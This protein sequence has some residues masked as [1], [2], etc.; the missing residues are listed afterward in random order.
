MSKPLKRNRA[1]VAGATALVVLA[2]GGAYAAIQNDVLFGPDKTA[3]PK[4]A[5]K[6]VTPQGYAVAPAG[7][8]TTIGHLPLN[9]AL[10]P[11][12]RTLL[13]TNNGQATQSLQLIDTHTGQVTQTLP[14]ATPESLYIGL[15]WS[16]DGTRAY[17]S[18]AANSKIRVL[19]FAEGKLTEGKPIALPTSAPD[20]TAVKLFPAGLAI[21]ADG[22][23]L[24]VAGQLGNTLSSIDV[25]SGQIET[26]AVGH[27]PVWV[28]LSKNGRTAYVS[29]QGADTVS[30]VDVSKAVPVTTGSIKVGLHPNKS[31]LSANGSRLYVANGDADTVSEIRVP[32]GK[33]GRTF[34]VA[35]KGNTLI[36]ANPT[37]LALGKH[38]STLYVTN[39]GT[40]DVAAV[41]LRSGT[42]AG[43]IP[44][45]WY[46][47]SITMAGDKLLV[48]NAKGYGA[49]PNNGPG[50]PNPESTATRSPDQY[51]G[52]MI[53]G[54]I[55]TI[56]APSGD[57]L[58]AWTRQV[59]Q[60]V[61]PVTAP[62]S[63]VPAKPG[64]ATPIKHV[65]YVVKENRTFD[66]VMGSLGKGNGDPGLNLFGDESAPNMRELARRFV[67]LDNFYADAE[68]SANGWNWVT[69]ANSNPYVEQMWPANYSSRNGGATNNA[70]LPELD[71]QP[72]DSYLWER[73][74]KAGVS[75]K[76]FGF[77]VTRK[78]DRFVGQDPVPDRATDHG[79]QGYDLACPDSRGT[80]TPTKTNCLTPRVDQWLKSFRAFEKAGSMPHVQFVRFGNDH[81]SGTKPGEP[82]PKA[83]VA[84]ND[85]A[86]GRLVE[87]VSH[88]TF[89][90]DTVILAT[91]DD[92]Q[93]GP[94]HV[95]AHRTLAWVISPYSQTGAVDSTFYSTSSM[96]RTVGLFAGIGPL[97]Q[98]DA[99]AT[100]MSRSFTTK[101]NL[102]PY[103]V[104]KP[105]TDMSARNAV[106]APMAA[107]SARQDLTKEDQID[108]R[109]FNQA[110][111]KSVRGTAAVMPEPV[112][113]VLGDTAT[114]E[115]EAERIEDA[116]Q[117]ARAKASGKPVVAREDD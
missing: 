106:G 114:A 12:G 109:T 89:W 87:A 73:F 57:Q 21:S 8:Q 91:E 70:G 82:T 29:N 85:Y 67:T 102:T 15:V 50:H 51:V 68:V 36:G 42:V 107:I 52:G 13:V 35:P 25:S 14:Y 43:H 69:Q 23:R 104:I 99:Y 32:S 76:N 66:Q 19:T 26:T 113:R 72:T 74:D 83:M 54:T 49:G 63:V 97:T 115:H 38:D 98:F 61:A 59:E 1:A 45:A 2:G 92:A 79:F 55:S 41:S 20:G 111:W 117:A 64:D 24:F 112:Y 40:N 65:I 44:T 28:T 81:T 53:A 93:N 62:S 58:A 56:P 10:H 9:A 86:F 3:G 37:G 100:P 77:Y 60:N 39:S 11:D 46:P 71:A 90:K 96:V 94:D 31:V 88:S 30:V 80:F 95:D 75:F 17:A 27:R 48:T 110:I 16:P 105:T 33:P 18:A 101:A 116:Q 47:S 4:A 6:A 5:D 84:D 22:K 34:A 78:G 108:E 103:T 7:S